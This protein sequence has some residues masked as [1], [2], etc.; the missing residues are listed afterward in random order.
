MFAAGV[1]VALA[2][3]MTNNSPNRVKRLTFAGVMVLSSIQAACVSEDQLTDDDIA[4]AEY[5]SESGSGYESGSGSGSGNSCDVPPQPCTPGCGWSCA[6]INVPAQGQYP[7][8]KTSGYAVNTWTYTLRATKYSVTW[9]TSTH[10]GVGFTA[11]TKTDWE[12]FSCID[13]NG[14]GIGDSTQAESGGWTTADDWVSANYNHGR[15]VLA[16]LNS[17]NATVTFKTGGKQPKAYQEAME[18]CIGWARVDGFCD[19]ACGNDAYTVPDGV[20]NDN[21]DPLHAE[22]IPKFSQ[23]K[24]YEGVVAGS[25]PARYSHVPFK[26]W[27]VARYGH[28]SNNDANAQ[29]AM[30][31]SCNSF[32]GWLDG[33]YDTLV[34][35]AHQCGP[36]LATI[37]SQIN[38]RIAGVCAANCGGT[39]TR[40]YSTN[41]TGDRNVA[42]YNSGLAAPNGDSSGVEPGDVACAAAGNYYQGPWGYTVCGM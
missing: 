8:V 39:R 27:R 21:D 15:T 17:P 4:S 1:A 14:D 9:A 13:T 42:L 38:S 26:H 23:R 37:N 25:D 34:S 29:N 24:R 2:R 31:N 41:P 28:N 3:R 16:S 19:F 20:K 22:D 32:K 35:P 5:R 7:A 30:M 10:T 40:Y 11:K 36:D 18:A 6:P 33:A 12:H